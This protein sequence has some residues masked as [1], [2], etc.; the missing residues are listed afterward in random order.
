MKESAAEQVATDGKAVEEKHPLLE[1]TPKTFHSFEEWLQRWNGTD[2]LAEKLGLMHSLTAINSWF[3]QDPEL[4]SFLLRTAD[5]YDYE[6]KFVTQEEQGYGFRKPESSKARKAIAEKAFGVLC[7]KF[8]RDDNKGGERPLWWWMLKEDILFQRVL[9]FFRKN[10]HG[11]IENCRILHYDGTSIE[12]QKG[13]LQ[14]FLR[15]F[16]RLGWKFHSFSDR[17][18]NEDIDK[19]IGD[20]LIAS[21]PQSIDIL[22]ELKELYWLNSQELDSASLKKLTEMALSANL[23]LPPIDVNSYHG[24]CRKP[25]SLEE[26]VLGGSIAAQVVL[27]HKIREKE[28]KRMN[29]LYEESR[30]QWETSNRQLELDRVEAQRRE[31]DRKAK[32]LAGSSGKSKHST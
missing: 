31:L 22:C 3:Q 21:R 17:G 24:S 8:F 2:F 32:E 26:A 27:L 29:A 7:L 6:S 23:H 13:I 4:V 30:Q 15:S 16:A 19:P 20:R 28:K 25:V 5:S 14:E 12:H 10:I 1:F 11:D 9:W 18:Y